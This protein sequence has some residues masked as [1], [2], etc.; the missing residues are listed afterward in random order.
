[1]E[2][3]SQHLQKNKIFLHALTSLNTKHR[4]HLLQNA[5]RSSILA[6]TEILYNILKGNV[7]IDDLTYQLL[8]KNKC[9]IRKVI[10]K[11]SW[12]QRKKHIEKASGVIVKI[13]KYMIPHIYE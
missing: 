1:M 9:N 11:Q 3:L 8:L 12:Q 5:V 10:Q 6:I 4:K 13:L 2:N 7:E